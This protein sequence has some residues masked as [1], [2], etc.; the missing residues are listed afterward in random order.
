VKPPYTITEKILK[1]VASISEKLGIINSAH[2]QKPPTELRKENRIKT[3][4]SSLQIE[5]NT[6]TI[7]QITAILENK[8]IIGPQADI[9]EV[10]NAIETYE[11]FNDFSPFDIDSLC[12]AHSILMKGLIDYPGKLRTGQVG[13]VKGSEVAHLAPPGELVKALLNDLFDYLENDDDLILI[14]SCV[15]HYEFEFIHPFVDG[16]G[17]MGRLWQTLI[18]NDK[19]PV[20][21]YLPVET[22]IKEKQKEYYE[23][24]SKSDKAGESTAFIEF[25]LHVIDIALKEV[26]YAQNKPLTQERRIELFKLIVKEREFTRKEYLN[27]Y[28]NISSATASRDLKYATD[29][30][31]INKHGELNKSKYKYND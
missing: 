17:R 5:G 12:K 23:A 19:Y 2:L 8:R 26:I 18:L 1:L 13:I 29:A 27:Q 31:I 24:L 15:F 22:I 16:N 6:L 10:K 3:I 7:E 9:Q 14:K 4:H 30:K 20:F 21:E 25:M 11:A 28:K